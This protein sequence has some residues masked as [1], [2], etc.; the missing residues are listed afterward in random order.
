MRVYRAADPG[1]G[2]GFRICKQCKRH[3]ITG[4]DLVVRRAACRGYSGQVPKIVH[5]PGMSMLTLLPGVDERSAGQRDSRSKKNP[6]LLYNTVVSL[7]LSLFR[8]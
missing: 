4:S 1:P 3:V 8:H 7:S 5:T 6:A 2:P